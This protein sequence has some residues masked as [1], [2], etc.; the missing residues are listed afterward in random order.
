M[1]MFYLNP[2]ANRTT[3]TRQP[4]G[5]AASAVRQFLLPIAAIYLSPTTTLDNAIRQSIY[6]NTITQQ[7]V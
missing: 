3:R 4:R 5:E 6:R 2:V 7:Y 1:N